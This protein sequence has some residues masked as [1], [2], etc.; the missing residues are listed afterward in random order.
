MMATHITTSINTT[1]GTIIVAKYAAA[2]KFSKKL[3]Y[4]SI[5]DDKSSIY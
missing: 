5:T 2:K 1:T 3:V 4:L